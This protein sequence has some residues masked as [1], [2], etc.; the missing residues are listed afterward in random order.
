MDTQTALSIVV[1]ALLPAVV[2]LVTNTLASSR[3]K[4]LTLL[5][6]SA[7]AGVLTPL[8]GSS[9]FNWQEVLASFAATFGTAVLTYYG[10]LKPT[11]ATQA[12]GEA[13]PGGIGP[14]VALPGYEDVPDEPDTFDPT[15]EVENQEVS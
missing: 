2:A 10:L 8:V 4:S 14:S 5:A 13:I 9:T 11:G 1:G 6:L 15:T 7:L 3:F 12:I